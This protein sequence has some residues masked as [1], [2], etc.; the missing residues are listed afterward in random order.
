VARC[1]RICGI[2]R[3]A[4]C[5]RGNRKSAQQPSCGAE[6]HGKRQETYTVFYTYTL[7]C[8][9]SLYTSNAYCRLY[10]TQNQVMATLCW[11][12][13]GQGHQRYHRR[14][15]S[16]RPADSKVRLVR[17]A[18]RRAAI[19]R[20]RPLSWVM[21]TEPMVDNA[22]PGDRIPGR[23]PEPRADRALTNLGLPGK[24][25]CAGRLAVS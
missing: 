1:I 7:T 10:L 3:A 18:C 21:R 15:K 11:F 12:E 13:F 14:A 9:N 19:A 24:P 23:E 25:P 2:D 16:R 8:L 20:A 22:A 5:G 4:S 17:D 6:S